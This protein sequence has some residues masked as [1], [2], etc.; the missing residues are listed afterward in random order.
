MSGLKTRLELL[1]EILDRSDVTDVTDAAGVDADRD[2][3]W[4]TADG[5]TWIIVHAVD[6]I[7]RLLCDVVTTM[8]GR[9]HTWLKVRHWEHEVIVRVLVAA[10]V[11]RLDDW[12]EDEQDGQGEQESKA[13]T[14]G[15]AVPDRPGRVFGDC[16]HPVW[17]AEWDGGE[18]TCQ[19]CADAFAFE[20]SG[21]QL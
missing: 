3:V 8:D 9:Q 5:R 12:A 2:R 6:H 15:E 10:G 13:P 21:G 4:I 7:G 1:D 18:R 16:G 17:R 20:V 19:R 11:V 14:A